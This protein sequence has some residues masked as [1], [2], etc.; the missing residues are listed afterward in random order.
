MVIPA[1]FAAQFFDNI[2]VLI[3]AFFS[4]S[5]AA[6]S[7]YIFNDTQDK[8]YDKKANKNNLFSQNKLTVKQ[9]YFYSLILF[10]IGIFITSFYEGIF[11]IIIYATINFLYSIKLKEIPYIDLII[12]VFG[13]FLRVFYGGV[14]TDI[15]ITNWLYAET[16]VLTFL[17]ILSKRIKEYNTYKK[18]NVIARKVLLK[19]NEKVLRY[20][21]VFFNVLVLIIYVFYCFNDE[22]VNRTDPNI[23]ITIPLVCFGLYQFIL[24]TFNNDSQTNPINVLLKNKAI[25]ITVFLWI[26]IWGYL[27][28]E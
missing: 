8:E 26:F 5:F 15:Y 7:V 22:V 4:F 10:L 3:G 9:G 17:I 19:Y 16:I 27:L 12:V 20:I 21:F 28:Y 23:W 2:C 13:F 25:L 6:S 14:V 1:F 11:V 18:S 24:S